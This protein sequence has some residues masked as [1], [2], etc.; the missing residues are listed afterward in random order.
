MGVSDFG[1]MARERY[2]LPPPTRPF[3]YFSKEKELKKKKKMVCFPVPY[4]LRGC[5]V[6]RSLSMLF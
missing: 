5:P 3:L 4:I 1:V 2:I 6:R